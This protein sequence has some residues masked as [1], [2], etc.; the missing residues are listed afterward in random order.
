MLDSL[1]INGFRTFDRLTVP[2]LGRVNLIVGKNNVGKTT[3][4]EAVHLLNS[5]LAVAEAAHHLLDRRQEYRVDEEDERRVDLTSLFH[6]GAARAEMFEVGALGASGLSARSQWRI[7]ERGD[8]GELRL[9]IVDEVADEDEADSESVLSFST[10]HGRRTVPMDGLPQRV[11]RRRVV[12]ADTDGSVFL[13][14]AGFEANGVD[15][16]KFWDR[17]A[18]TEREDDVLEALRLIEPSLERLVMVGGPRYRR[19]LARL[20]GREPLAL[21]SMGDGMSRLFELA[22]GLVNVARGGTFLIDEVDSGLHFAALQDVWR[23]VF[24]MAT[25]L[26]L[27]VFATT[28]SWDCIE[29]FQVAASAHP[30]EG[31]L[32]RLANVEGSVQAE[33]FSE[34]DLEVITRGSIE[35]R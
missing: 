14:L 3:L 28:H 6:L 7:R 35:V 5:G 19:P 16:A 17:I 26:D 10:P 15:S 32:V 12:R 21:R 23:L 27:Q 22:V 11:F 24:K 30:E 9:R 13:P 33:C 29:A 4:L 31:V 34:A 18:L 20:K 25:Q 2:T 1:Q 8:D